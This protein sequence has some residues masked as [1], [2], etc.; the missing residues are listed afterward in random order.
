MANIK[1]GGTTAI[2]E[3]GGTVTL[4]N[5]V[6]DNI[7][8]LGTVTSGHC[9]VSDVVKLYSNTLSTTASSVDING[10]F[11]DTKYSHYRLLAVGLRTSAAG[12]TFK[13]RVMT[14]G[15]VDT[16]NIYWNAGGGNYSQAGTPIAMVR[17]DND[18]ANFAY[19]DCTWGPP[20]TSSNATANF[21]ITFAEPQHTTYHKTFA[22]AS[23]SGGH[24]GGDDYTRYE[25]ITVSAKTTTALTGVSIFPNSSNWNKGTFMLYGYKK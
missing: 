1:L 20:H 21:E 23:W 9:Q 22:I 2:T 25:Y 24:D 11:D 16:G 13:F 7:T 12:G 18:G 5:A 6:Q 10:Y 8:R 14:G 3:S 17:A 19:M 15:S 4:D